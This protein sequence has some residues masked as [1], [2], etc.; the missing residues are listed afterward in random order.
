M[1]RSP[2]HGR[3][4]EAGW[5]TIKMKRSINL[6]LAGSY[7]VSLTFSNVAVHAEESGLQ[8]RPLVADTAYLLGPEDELSIRVNDLDEF[9]S[10]PLRI[11]PNGMLDLPIVG[12][13]KAG[14][15][16]SEQVKADVVER[17][18]SILKKPEVSL[19]VT[20]FH[21]QPVSVL[22]AVNQ[23]GVHQLQGPK[24]LLEMVSAAGGLR[25][26]AGGKLVIT[27]QIEWGSLPLP[28]AHPDKSGAFSTAELRLENITNGRAPEHNIYLRPHD[29]ISVSRADL[30]YVIGE[31]KKA[32]GFTLASQE[33]ISVLQ[34]LALAQGLDR[35]ASPKKARI[36]RKDAE[37]AK[38]VDIPVNVRK[39]LDGEAADVALQAED[40]LFI[41]NNLP[42]SVALRTAEVA[43]Q[44]GTGLVIWRR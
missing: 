35:T 42:R 27:R 30:V 31:V 16:S 3:G 14:G 15:R 22:G 43:I 18:R 5:S 38:R 28:T 8:T 37:T 23:P 34:A 6:L 39:I 9:G 1:G 13:L 7:W 2:E 12:P 32:G 40:I 20:S 26:E 21:S 25:P 11:D 41:P 24:R 4:S 33:N 29:V 36:L 10:K 19:T 44:V 17:L